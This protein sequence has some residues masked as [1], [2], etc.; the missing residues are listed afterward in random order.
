MR[1]IH[2]RL[3]V[4]IIPLLLLS[5]RPNGASE[6]SMPADSTEVAFEMAGAGEA[7]ILVPVH[8]NGE[9]PFQ[10][11][12]DTGATMTCLDEQLAD[13]LQLSDQP[14]VIG[15]GASV[16]GSGQVRIVA[17]DSLR[18]G[19]V[20]AKDLSACALNLESL[21]QVGLEPRGLLGLNFL[22]SFR[23][24][25]DFDRNIARFDQ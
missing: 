21:Q 6:T 5:C 4:L 10:F 3:T 24:T 13:S 14:G 9:G 22:R 7:A 15:R 16:Q 2:P 23:V 20:G 19:E 17:V 8:V 12:L 11:V 1:L 25:L 18:V